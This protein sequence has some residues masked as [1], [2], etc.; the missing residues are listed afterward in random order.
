M[1]V[2]GVNGYIDKENGILYLKRIDVFAGLEIHHYSV[3]KGTDGE[4][5]FIWFM[6]IE[7]GDS[8]KFVC[9]CDYSDYTDE[10]ISENLFNNITCAMDAYQYHIE[11]R[12]LLFVDKIRKDVIQVIK[13]TTGNEK[14]KFYKI[15]WE[16]MNMKRDV[17]EIDGV[18]GYLNEFDNMLYL[19]FDTICEKLVIFGVTKLNSIMD[20]DTFVKWRVPFCS[21]G[22]TKIYKTFVLVLEDE[23]EYTDGYISEKL[24]KRMIEDMRRYKVHFTP[25]QTTFI[26]NVNDTVIPTLKKLCKKRQGEKDVYDLD[27]E[28]V[29]IEDLLFNY[30]KMHQ[31]LKELKT[32]VKKYKGD[33]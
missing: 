22:S 6:E 14:D 24:F 10:Y 32:I 7:D 3:F 1:F 29:S 4:R 16:E 5:F 11:A 33:E 13:K 21:E 31:E 12:K 2:E 20:D 15:H 26:N 18:K 27:P 17:L 28:K 19:K 30:R 8:K 25:E 9:K 23:C